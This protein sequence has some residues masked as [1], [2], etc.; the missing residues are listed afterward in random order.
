MD[1]RILGPFEAF[2]D[3]R[4][5]SLGGVR[6]RAVLAFLLLH[7]NETVTRD[8]IVDELWGENPPPTAV[9]VLQNCVSA[10]R[11][12][13]RGGADTLRTVG[14][15][16]ALRVAPDEL[17]RDRFE[18]L[19]AE[20]RAA[21]SA[22]DCADAAERLR[23]ALALWRG[24]PLSDFAYE[25]FAQEEINRLE[26]LHLAAVEERIDADLGV[27]RH[28]EVVP[29]LEALVARHK[30]RE[31]L[32][33]QL[34]LALYRSGRQAEALEAYHAARR[35]LQA[36]LGIEPGRSL[37]ELERAIL[38]QDPTLDPPTAQDAPPRGRG[39]VR[40]GRL[41]A[42]PL[43][44]REDELTLLE[45]GLEDTLAGRGRLFVVVGEA[46][47]GKTQLADEIASRAKQRGC[48]ILW[49]R[50]WHGGGAPAYWPW[51]QALREIGRPVPEPEGADD[52][53]RFRFF[54]AVTEAV[55]GAASEQPLLLVFDD[56]QAA[57]EDS[58]LLLEF[59]A[60][61]LPEMAALV[62]AL[63]RADTARL[64][65]LSRHATRTLRLE[66]RA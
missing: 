61:E 63:G 43:V 28:V 33:G 66:Q 37:H 1:Y 25:R 14:G 34:M 30:L 23:N 24:S 26:E 40:A 13:L 19:L 41:A 62:L 2:D 51:R 16:Y 8:V 48:R 39:I 36:E 3:G 57:D 44:G 64:D 65:E 10:L 55:R 20:G 47:A 15:A 56:L 58:L 18:S 11:K 22:G 21:L 52:A 27:G 17:D 50:G 46:G 5:I 53:A 45:A 32:H 35:T 6:Q 31:R 9:K 38:S 7:G 49:G 42:S 60:S 59:V 12:E 54:E 4:R 29:E